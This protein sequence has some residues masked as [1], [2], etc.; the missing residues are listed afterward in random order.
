MVTDDV[1]LC[2]YQWL[3]EEQKVVVIWHRSKM[4]KKSEKAVKRA[5]ITKKNS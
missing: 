1:K 4:V 2:W 3:F 5:V